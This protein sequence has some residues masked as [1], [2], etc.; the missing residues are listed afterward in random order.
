MV[1]GRSSNYIRNAHYRDDCFNYSTRFEFKELINTHIKVEKIAENLRKQINRDP[2]FDP[3]DAFKVC[4]INNDGIIT[5]NEL[6]RVLDSRGFNSSELE[7][8]T[9]MNKLD[10]NRDGKVSYAEFIDEVRPKILF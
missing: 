4:D 3:Y 8:S 6:R 5:K 1:N 2:S 10:K 9:L 7:I